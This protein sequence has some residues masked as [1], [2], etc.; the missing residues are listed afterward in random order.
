MK[1]KLC[2]EGMKTVSGA[3]V[4]LVVCF[5]VFTGW[6]VCFAQ[7]APLNGLEHAV[8]LKYLLNLFVGYV[9]MKP[10]AHFFQ[11]DTYIIAFMTLSDDTE[12]MIPFYK[13]IPVM[14]I[15]SLSAVL[16]FVIYLVSV[17]WFFRKRVQRKLQAGEKE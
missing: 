12:Q 8:T 14:W 10:I 5:L 4:Y 9:F 6:L 15:Y 7:H 17:K 3:V 13:E 1:I 2:G 11:I 16:T